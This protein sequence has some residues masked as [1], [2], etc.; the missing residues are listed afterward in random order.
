MDKIE[1]VICIL[2]KDRRLFVD[3]VRTIEP[4]AKYENAYTLVGSH[5]KFIKCNTAK[6]ADKYIFNNVI[7]CS[8]MAGEEKEIRD[9]RNKLVL[10]M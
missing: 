4:K 8:D 7:I 6:E 3:T 9:V 2:T 5:F 10:R 1:Q